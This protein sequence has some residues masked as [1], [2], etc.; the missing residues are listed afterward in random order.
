MKF[1][2]KT[3]DANG[4]VPTTAPSNRLRLLAVVQ[5]GE[6]MPYTGDYDLT[7]TVSSQAGQLQLAGQTTISKFV[8]LQNG[9]PA[10]TEDKI[11]IVNDVK[12]DTNAK[13][14][15]INTIALDHAQQQRR[16]RQPRGS[17]ADWETRASSTA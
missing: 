16:Q 10:F 8:V 2:D 9:K 11:L 13:N 1:A 12:A 14:A 17:I 7:Q 5:G 4:K 6:Q 3:T 15:T